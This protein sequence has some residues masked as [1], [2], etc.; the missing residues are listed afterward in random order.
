[1]IKLYWTN[2]M[3][4]GCNDEKIEGS[5]IG[6]FRDLAASTRAANV[7]LETQGIRRNSPFSRLCLDARGREWEDFGSWSHF[8]VRED[9]EE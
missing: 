8:F 1:M 4:M 5:V 9:V 7:W 6:T 3:P 2:N